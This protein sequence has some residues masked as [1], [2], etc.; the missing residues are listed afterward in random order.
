MT[1]LFDMFPETNDTKRCQYVLWTLALF[2]GKYKLKRFEYPT[3]AIVEVNRVLTELGIETIDEPTLNSILENEEG[4]NIH[5]MRK[6][7]VFTLQPT[8]WASDD[9]II[10]LRQMSEHP[11]IL[12]NTYNYYLNLQ[13]ELGIKDF[14]T[15]VKFKNDEQDLILDLYFINDNDEEV[16][17]SII[18]EKNVNQERLDKAAERLKR[19]IN[20]RT[21]QTCFSKPIP[22][23]PNKVK[24]I[25]IL[26]YENR[27][28][29]I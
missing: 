7:V 28:V 19:T 20:Y 2:N 1:T 29:E 21:G 27:F 11:D 6:L 16:F 18:F 12:E 9:K 10:E 8:F 3:K 15:L 17:A 5:D 25:I 26:P 24:F 4:F 22:I 23:N 14:R 13:K